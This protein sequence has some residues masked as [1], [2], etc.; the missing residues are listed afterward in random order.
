MYPMYQYSDKELKELLTTLT[1]LI[2]T[3]EQENSH[4]WNY[5]DMKNIRY[6]AKKL[7]IGDYSVM[8]PQNRNYGI[9]RD[10]FFPISVERKRSIDELAGT[11]K[12]RTRFENELIRSQKLH[13]TLLVEDANGYENIIKA[14]YRSKYEPKALVASLKTFESRYGFSTIF[15]PKS[16]TGDFLYNHFYYYVRNI[17]KFF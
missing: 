3:R 8:L 2:D 7:Q 16:V 11:I 9:T 13:F 15:I 12:E 10:L 6:Q 5:F 17:L 14:K 4:I 1:V